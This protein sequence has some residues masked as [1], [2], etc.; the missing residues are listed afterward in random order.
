MQA[1]DS[2]KLPIFK[3]YTEATHQ[4]LRASVKFIETLLTDRSPHEQFAFTAVS[5]LEQMMIKSLTEPLAEQKQ[6]SQITII[7]VG[8]SVILVLV[9]GVSAI[10]WNFQV[11]TLATVSSIL[12]GIIS[13]LLFVQLQRSRQ[14]LKKNQETIRQEFAGAIERF[15]GGTSTQISPRTTRSEKKQ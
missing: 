15:Y 10:F 11:G 12:T 8:I 6:W 2:G 14:S 3:N 5:D 4:V 9:G 7:F 1:A 13:S